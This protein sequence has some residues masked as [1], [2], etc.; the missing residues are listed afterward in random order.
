MATW[1]QLKNSPNLKQNLI[2]RAD[3]LASIRSFFQENGFL[4]VET[5][6]LVPSVIPES[7]LETF[8]T[9]LLN[10]RGE[11]KRM[12]LTASPEAT[13]KKLL[14]AGVGNLFEITKS[15]RNG[16]TDSLTHNPEFTILEWYRVH[17][18]YKESMIDCCNLLCAIA[19]NLHRFNPKRFPNPDGIV[20]QEKSIS[21][22]SPW[23]HVSVFEAMEKYAGITLDDIT[24]KKATGVQNIFPVEKIAA[25]AQKKGYRIEQRRTWEDIFNQIFLNEVE[26]KLANE[27]KPVIL[28]GYPSPMA[29]LA[30]LKKTDNRLC[31]R[32]ELYIGGLEL[33]DCYSELQNPTEQKKRFE[34]EITKINDM[35]K[36]KIIPDSDFLDALEHGLPPS[37]GVAL[38]IDRLTMLFTNSTDISDVRVTVLSL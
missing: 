29:A 13:Q 4:E 14:V 5:P 9:E 23:I 1:Q 31:E 38:G 27:K 37:S 28:Y 6:L 8:T 21:L 20:Y 17:A 15:F 36:T 18:T 30:K 3:I 22:K 7:Y 16:E 32:F 33:A 24:D 26:S 34:I 19:I 11:K 25:I 10:R 2:I 35:N 12:F